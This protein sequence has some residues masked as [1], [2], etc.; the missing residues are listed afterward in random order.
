LFIYEYET[1][2]LT[3]KQE[4][5]IGL[6]RESESILTIAKGLGIKILK[7]LQDSGDQFFGDGNSNYL[8]IIAFFSLGAI[9]P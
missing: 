8:R 5:Y 1:W 9:A 7:Y 3:P 2:S 4:T 6:V